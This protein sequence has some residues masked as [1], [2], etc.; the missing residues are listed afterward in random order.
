MPC[1]A[2]FTVLIIC[3]QVKRYTLG[4]SLVGAFGIGLA[5]TMVSVGALA[6]WSA[7]HAEKKFRGFGNFMRKAP[8]FSSVIL[9][10]V[11]VYMAWHG[12]L[13]LSGGH[14]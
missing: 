2:A 9:L 8:Y 13:G 6:A 10:F 4:F 11:A 1:P 12:W 7:R 5:L 14:H 3:L